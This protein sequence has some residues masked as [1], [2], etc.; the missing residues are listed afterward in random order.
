MTVEVAEDRPASLMVDAS[1][2]AC[3]VVV[4]TRG[5]GGLKG[6]L[7]GSVS[8]QLIQHAHCPVAVVRER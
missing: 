2:N 8:Q 3:L 4:G 6:M 5:R 7:L 1:R